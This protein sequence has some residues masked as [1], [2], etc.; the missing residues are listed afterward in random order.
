M[1]TEQ[2]EVRKMSKDVYALKIEKHMA[3]M[4][5]IFNTLST[6]QKTNDDGDIVVKLAKL[7]RYLGDLAYLIGL[8]LISFKR[9]LAVG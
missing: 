4:R 2:I 9:Y 7:P 5:E 1:T 6:K 3:K 8:V